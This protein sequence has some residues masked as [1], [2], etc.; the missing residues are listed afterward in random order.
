MC[1]LVDMYVCVSVGLCAVS[2]LHAHM[3]VCVQVYTCGKVLAM[4][5]SAH[6]VC[7]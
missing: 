5:V 2:A 7:V 6:N 3:H 1:T 4:H